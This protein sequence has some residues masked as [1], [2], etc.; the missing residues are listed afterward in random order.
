MRQCDD[1]GLSGVPLADG[2]LRDGSLGRLPLPRGPG[3]TFTMCISGLV[4][5]VEAHL[6]T[7]EAAALL[8]P[9]APVISNS[10]HTF[11][12]NCSAVMSFFS[13]LKSN[14]FT[15]FSTSWP[16]EWLWLLSL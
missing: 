13:R 7:T 10:W 1:E 4:V 6:A 14:N 8:C 16:L 5:V 15:I 12:C 9:Q 3:F 11:C 2:T